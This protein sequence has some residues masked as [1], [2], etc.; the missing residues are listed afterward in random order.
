M[1]TN[2]NTVDIG[3][4]PPRAEREFEFIVKN[5]SNDTIAL[6]SIMTP[7]NCIDATVTDI[8]PTSTGTIRISFHASDSYGIFHHPIV[9]RYEGVATPIIIHLYGMVSL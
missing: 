7:C 5:Q 9:V 1:K 2:K 3:T 4:V 6:S 8:M